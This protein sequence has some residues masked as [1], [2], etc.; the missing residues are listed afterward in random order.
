MA[1]GVTIGFSDEEA[2]GVS[3]EVSNGMADGMCPDN[4]VANG[5]SDIKNNKIFKYFSGGGCS[6]F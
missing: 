1:D 6:S 4:G 5:V 3:D 2:N